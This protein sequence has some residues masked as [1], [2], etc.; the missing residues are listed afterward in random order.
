MLFLPFVPRVAL[1]RFAA[2]PMPVPVGQLP[3]VAGREARTEWWNPASG[4]VGAM[5]AGALRAARGG[6]GVAGEPSFLFLGVV[7]P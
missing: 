1:R 6:L 2:P 7:R 4:R 5:R 3:S